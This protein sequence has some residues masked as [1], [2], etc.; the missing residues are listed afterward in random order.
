LL[1]IIFRRR[2]PRPLATGVAREIVGE[3]AEAANDKRCWDLRNA[4]G[5]LDGKQPF[6]GT[7]LALLADAAGVRYTNRKFGSAPAQ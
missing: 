4:I 3:G 7:L 5:W 2:L 1:C 6:F